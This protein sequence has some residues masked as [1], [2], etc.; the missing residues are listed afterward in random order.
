MST[1]AN[2]FD[3]IMASVSQVEQAIKQEDAMA[4]WYKQMLNGESK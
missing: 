3:E 2:E 1:T 4:D